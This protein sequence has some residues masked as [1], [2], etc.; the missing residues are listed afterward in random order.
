[1]SLAKLL[2]VSSSLLV[3]GACAEDDDDHYRGY[4]PPPPDTTGT[5]EFQWSIGGERD[6]A[7]CASAGALTFQ[8]LIADGGYVVDDIVADCESFE[9]SMPLY[10]DDFRAR[11][12]LVNN[13]GFPVLRRIVED[14][15]V[16]EEGRVTRL[17]IDFPLPPVPLSPDAG[18]MPPVS[19]ADA[20]APPVEVIDAGSSDA[21]P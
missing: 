12:A 14:L 11:S 13:N 17:V 1:V 20:G 16:I 7:A 6:P 2:V 8:S 21:A 18:G 10:T 19:E 4:P 9:A 5:L 15:F 3:L